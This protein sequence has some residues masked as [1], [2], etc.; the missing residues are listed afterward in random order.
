M[1]GV[2]VCGSIGLRCEVV[3]IG[4]KRFLCI[5]ILGIFIIGVR[6]LSLSLKDIHY[7]F[8]RSF[9]NFSDDYF[10]KHFSNLFKYLYCFK[11]LFLNHYCS[12]VKKYFPLIHNQIESRLYYFSS[13]N[14]AFHFYLSHYLS[15][16]SISL[17]YSLS[18]QFTHL[19]ILTIYGF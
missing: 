3:I 8:I 11:Y 15:I 13:Q 12:I 9:Q 1:P 17:L 14:S 18:L 19:N 4:W 10:V 5:R 6:R 2:I 16:Y 7:C